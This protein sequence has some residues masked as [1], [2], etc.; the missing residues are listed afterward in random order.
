MLS[1]RSS[2]LTTIFCAPPAVAARASSSRR[3]PDARPITL[4]SLTSPARFL[5]LLLLCAFTLTSCKERAQSPRN[6]SQSPQQPSTSALPTATTTDN[7][8]TTPSSSPL[9]IVA[10]SPALAQIIRDLGA[11]S[12]LIGRHGFDTLSDPAI[13][14]CGDQSGLDTE[15]LIRQRPTHLFTQLTSTPTSLPPAL[16]SITTHNFRLLSLAD[17]RSA[18]TTL[19]TLLALPTAAS[20]LLTRLD[21]SLTPLP[22]TT[23]APLGPVLLLYSTDPPTVLGPGSFHHEILLALGATPAPTA[24]APF[25]T[26]D[27]E[28]LARIAPS[29]IILIH[30]RA[31]HAPASANDWPTLRARLGSLATLNIPAITSRRVALIDD[32]AAATP[33][34]TLISLT[35]QLRTTLTTLAQSPRATTTPLPA[36]PHTPDTTT[37]P[38]TPTPR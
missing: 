38:P 12:S 9:R 27:A 23:T 15:A 35:T 11:S 26:L 1:P 8:S 2:I 28:G 14:V 10:L 36:T 18:I 16:D 37:T 30:P 34:S 13:P 32:P 20:S 17:V 7:S 24:D 19:G 4:A 29:T 31:I 6:Q 21:E 25:I 22:T 33:G 3:I 5:P